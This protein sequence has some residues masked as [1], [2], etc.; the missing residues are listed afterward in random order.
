VLIQLIRKRFLNFPLGPSGT[1]FE[2]D[3]LSAKAALHQ[4]LATYLGIA[5]D[6]TGMVLVLL[7]PQ[8]LTDV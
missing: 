2:A 6:F 5:S 7:I 3:V 1:R 8:A 4:V